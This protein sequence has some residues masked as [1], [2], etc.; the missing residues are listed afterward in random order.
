MA[1]EIIWSPVALDDIEAIGKYIA[2]GSVFY[3][4]S[5]VNRI[6]ETTQSLIQF[7]KSGRIVPEF[8]EKYNYRHLHTFIYVILR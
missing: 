3:A 2:K 7:P 8:N 5:T 6:Y 4:E 1:H